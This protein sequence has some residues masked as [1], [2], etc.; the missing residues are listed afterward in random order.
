MTDRAL[1]RIFEGDLKAQN[2]GMAITMAELT[3][4]LKQEFQV[5]A[6][7]LAFRRAQDGKGHRTYELVGTTQTGGKIVRKLEAR[8]EL[9]ALDAARAMVPTIHIPKKKRTPTSGRLKDYE[10][11]ALIEMGKRKAGRA[12]ID[13]NQ[14]QVRAT[15]AWLQE[16]GLV[17]NEMN[18]LDRIGDT[19]QSTGTRRD[20]ILAAN[21]LARMANVVFEVPEDLRYIQPKPPVRQ[22]ITEEEIFE[23]L[24]ATRGKVPP[25][26]HWILSVVA[27][28]GI[29]GN[30]T[31]S[32]KIP[33]G[34]IEVGTTIPYWCSKRAVAGFTTPSTDWWDAFCVDGPPGYLKELIT[35]HDHAASEELQ[36]EVSRLINDVSNTVRRRIPEEYRHILR[37]RQLRH[38]AG[39]RLLAMGV[40]PLHVCQ[41]L[42][43]SM[44]ML[45][46]V[47]SQF[48]KSKA[49][50][51]VLE[52]YNRRS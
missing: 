42:G 44:R 22:V 10:R 35:P 45:E 26:H 34:I 36:G 49:A 24:S 18:L 17:I 51:A 31:L 14:A 3:K 12:T 39:S 11:M 33:E 32:L 46:Q 52:A 2:T 47:Y 48:F 37:F 29:R 41:I 38:Q 7:G 1:R 20:S 5:E 15:V 21:T 28:T 4:K 30:E 6:L 23:A 9:E 16:R 8:S 13:R 50:S 25:E 40:E 27:I 19:P 43:T